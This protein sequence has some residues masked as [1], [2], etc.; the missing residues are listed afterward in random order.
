MNNKN[1]VWVASFPK[2]GNTWMRSILTALIY[3]DN[4]K[5][6]FNLLSNIDQFENIK[7]FEFIKKINENDY[8][9]LNKMENISKYWQ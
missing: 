1:I 2:S 8:N 6:D 5:F 4:G 7:N 3:A 9:N